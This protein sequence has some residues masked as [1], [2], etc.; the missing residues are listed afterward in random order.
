[1]THFSLAY[2]IL[3]TPRKCG[4]FGVC[5]D[6]IPWQ[7]NYLIWGGGGGGGGV[8]FD[9]RKGAK[10]IISKLHHFFSIYGCW[11]KDVHL[12]AN[13]CARQNKNNTMIQ[14][15]TWRVKTGLPSNITHSFL[16]VGHTKFS[17]DWCFGF[18]KKEILFDNSCFSHGG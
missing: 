4:I 18:L 12:H 9:T 13:N 2:Y 16:V 6:I 3:L 14:Y 8:A 11:E 7:V 1:M 10:N 5:K 17:P 15:L